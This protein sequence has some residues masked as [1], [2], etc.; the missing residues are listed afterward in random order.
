M[1]ADQCLSVDAVIVGS[2]FAGALV[3][4][5]LGSAGKRVLMLEAGPEIPPNINGYMQRFFNAVAKVPESPYPP[6]LF[7]DGRLNDP[8]KVNAGRPT[9]VMLGPGWKDPAQSYLVQNGPMPFG[10]TYERIGGGTGLHWLGTCLRFLPNDFKMQTLYGQFADWPISYEDLDKDLEHSWYAKAEAELG[11]SADADA[12]QYLGIHFPKDYSYPMPGIP[13]SWVDQTIANKIAGMT[14]DDVALQITGTPAARNSQPYRQ[15]RACAGNTNCIPI[16]PIQAKYDPTITVNAALRTG[17]VTIMY[18][19]V[20]SEVVV[21]ENGRISQ[22]NYLQYGAESGPQTGSGCVSAKVF[23]IAGNAIE[24]PR[25]LLM[26]RNEGRTPYGVANSSGLVGRN[27]MDHPYYVTWGLMPEQVFPYRGPLST[28]GIEDLRDGKFRGQRGAF[29]IE[30]GNEGW[31]FVVGGVG[32]GDDPGVTT[33][34]FINGMNIS[35]LNTGNENLFGTELVKRLNDRITRQFRL[36]FLIEQSPDATN[37]VT[38][39]EQHKDGLGLPRPQIDYNLSDYTKM[40][41]AAAKKASDAIFARLGA[42]EHTA[43]PGAGDPN[44]FDWDIDGKS[45]RLNFLGA[46]HLVGTYR[47]GTDKSNSVVDREQRSWDH[48]NLYLVGS[49]VFPTVGTANPTLTLAALSLWAAD[50]ML[51]TDLN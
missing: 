15:R 23:I 32:S 29:R 4:L 24:T 6:E 22:I 7:R 9:S 2:G 8:G 36:G 17:N 44:A 19:T 34:D 30:V 48:R 14:I 51:R 33:V 43:P 16:C 40:G 11:V 47:M 46:G 50:T 31:N 21:G 37:R 38:I 18:R 1:A 49:G 25:L 3:A 12:Q 35:G 41:I 13:L 26:S 45:T 5:Q 10:S 39:S 27:L 20:A 42:K 28:A